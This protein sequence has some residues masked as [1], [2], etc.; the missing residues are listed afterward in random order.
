MVLTPHW[1]RSIETSPWRW[2]PLVEENLRRFAN[3][4]PLLN[5]VDQHA[6]Y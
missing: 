4:E 5:L 1:G 6:G 2:Q 3:R